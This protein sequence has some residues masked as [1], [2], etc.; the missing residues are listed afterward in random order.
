MSGDNGGKTSSSV[1]RGRPNRSN[2]GPAVSSSFAG[3][4]TSKSN[5]LDDFDFFPFFFFDG[6]A[7]D[8][9]V[10]VAPNPPPAKRVD[11]DS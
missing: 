4:D 6:A 8:L 7:E 3:V 9:L 5:R 11:V 10:L 1:G 2:F